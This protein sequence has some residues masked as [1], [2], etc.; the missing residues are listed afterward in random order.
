MK[1]IRRFSDPMEHRWG[2]R[3]AL[4]IDV[5]LDA[6]C[7]CQGDGVLR[8]LSVSGGY[9]TTKLELSV[10]ANLVVRIRDQQ[11]LVACVVRRDAAGVAVEWRDMGCDTLIGLLG[12]VGTQSDQRDRAF[13]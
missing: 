11:E 1:P 7:C 4:T 12:Q 3:V 10:F 8:E 6:G 9:I 5:K 2:E 13:A